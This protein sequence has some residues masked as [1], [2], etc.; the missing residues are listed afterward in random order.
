MLEEAGDEEGSVE[1]QVGVFWRG[2]AGQATKEGYSHGAEQLELL[3]IPPA[4]GQRVI[5][6]HQ[7]FNW[8]ENMRCFKHQSLSWLNTGRM[9][10]Q[11]P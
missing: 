7:G 8:L 3:P 4:A 11:Q 2:G 9:V 6:I 5:R 10:T 1:E